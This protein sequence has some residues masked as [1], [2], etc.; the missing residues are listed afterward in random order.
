MAFLYILQ[1]DSSGRFYIGSTT[2]P[3]RR[4]SEHQRGKTPSTRGRGPWRLVYREEFPTL[5]AARQRERQLKSWK[6]HRAI[7]DLIAAKSLQG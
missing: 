4:L 3:D 7:A 5:K 2:D 6:S 1:S